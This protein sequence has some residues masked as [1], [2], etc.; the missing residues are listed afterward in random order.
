MA[1]LYTVKEAAAELRLS[2]ATVYALVE[3][4]KIRHIR[5]GQRILFTPEN[6]SDF[7][8]AATVP[9]GGGA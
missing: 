4:R 7:I 5:F 1:Q 6:L 9:A 2:A 3:N 8:Q